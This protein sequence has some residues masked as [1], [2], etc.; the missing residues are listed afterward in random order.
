MHARSTRTLADVRDSFIETEGVSLPQMAP[1]VVPC[2]YP[3]RFSVPCT[4]SSIRKNFYSLKRKK[5]F[6]FLRKKRGEI[7]KDEKILLFFC[8][9]VW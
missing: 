6:L 4:G 5:N 7:M 1:R 9:Y 2:K 8:F 3:P